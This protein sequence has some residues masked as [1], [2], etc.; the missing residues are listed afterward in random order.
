M[1]LAINYPFVLA[2]SFD[3]LMRSHPSVPL[4]LMW[5]VAMLSFHQDVKHPNFGF[6]PIS[7]MVAITC[8]VVLLVF[9]FTHGDWVNFLIVPVLAWLHFQFTKRWRARP[10]A[11]W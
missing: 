2:F 1:H 7:Q 9:G 8:L 4:V 5:G 6:G 10:G 11:W 3:D